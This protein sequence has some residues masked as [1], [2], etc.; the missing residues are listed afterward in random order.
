MINDETKSLKR[1]LLCPII[2]TKYWLKRHSS[3]KY[4]VIFIQQILRGYFIFTSNKSIYFYIKRSF[5]IEIYRFDKRTQH[6][7]TLTLRKHIQKNEKC[8]LHLEQKLIEYFSVIIDLN[9]CICLSK[10][11]CKHKTCCYNFDCNPLDTR[12]DRLL[13]SQ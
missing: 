11:S 4:E 6:S 7:S 2:F 3:V 8:F 10:A 12:L 1:S 13:R 9:L 5:R